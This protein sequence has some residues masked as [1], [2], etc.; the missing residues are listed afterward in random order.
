VAEVQ[1]GLDGRGR[2]WA[3]VVSRYNEL[4][5]EK[6]AQAARACLLQHGADD[7]AIDTVL[8]PGAWELPYA[9]LL[10][11]RSG[12]Y[13]GIVGLG[14][15]VRGE[16]AH[17]DYVAGGANTGLMQVMLEHGVPVGNGVLT[18][19]DMDQALERAGGR[20]GNKGWEA[21]LSVLEMAG[22][23]APMRSMDAGT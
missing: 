7:A 14:C 5:T 1:G 20:H 23:A 9:A 4:A 10:A 3:L 11:A 17:F 6:L 21:A 15:V 2:R 13:A 8:V 18:T 19:E 22:L 12:R 16:T